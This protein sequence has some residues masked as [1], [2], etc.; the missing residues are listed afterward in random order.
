MHRVF[1]YG[2]L[3][4]S[5]ANNMFMSDSVYLG[6]HKTTAEYAMVDLGFC[7]GV[8]GQ[9]DSVITGEVYAVDD[10]AL[11]SLD[12]LEGHPVIYCR[13]L[14]STCWGD[15][16]MYLYQQSNTL[17]RKIVSGDWMQY[18]KGTEPCY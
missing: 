3:R 4:N 5:G 18:L 10:E 1:V 12:M 13:E 9:G 14:I 7:P 11:A 15:A 17:D 16:W 2:T 8:V 6:E